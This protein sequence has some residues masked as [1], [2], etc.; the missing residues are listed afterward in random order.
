[1]L[2][3]AEDTGQ[4]R[5]RKRGGKDGKEIIHNDCFLHNLLIMQLRNQPAPNQIK[6]NQKFRVFVRHE[7]D[8]LGMDRITTFRRSVSDEYL[9]NA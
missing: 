6:S 1:M 8:V 5:K 3:P 7:T 4:R 9:C 2:G